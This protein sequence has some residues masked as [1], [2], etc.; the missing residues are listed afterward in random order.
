MGKEI[1]NYKNEKQ[2][3]ANSIKQKTEEIHAQNKTIQEYENM[4]SKIETTIEKQETQ[5]KSITDNQSKIQN[6]LNQTKNEMKSLQKEL[7]EIIQKHQQLERK[8]FESQDNSLSNE[9]NI[10]QLEDTLKQKENT[11]DILKSNLEDNKKFIENNQNHKTNEIEIHNSTQQDHN[12]IIKQNT[13]ANTISQPVPTTKTL[14]HENVPTKV[15]ENIAQNINNNNSKTHEVLSET[16][17]KISIPSD[18]I[19]NVIGK[20]GYRVQQIQNNCDVK[21]HTK[22]QNRSIQ[23]IKVTGNEHQVNTS[24][25]EIKNI[26]TCANYLNKTCY[27]GRHCK[28]LHYSLHPKVINNQQTT[29]RAE[30][31]TNPIN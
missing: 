19:G 4:C 12:Y 16:T 27:Y 10:K 20:N 22:F 8:Y 29:S 18:L 2:I 23:D 26:V 25:N 13:K 15:T 5:I 31:T 14:N 30:R 1:E 3:Q 21:I 28:F 6:Y 11:I 9:A 7:P 24:L 17:K